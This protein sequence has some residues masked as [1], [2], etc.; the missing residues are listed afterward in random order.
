MWIKSKNTNFSVFLDHYQQYKYPFTV[1]IIHLLQM[2]LGIATVLYLIK[3]M[4][5]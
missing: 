2:F 4:I 3:I 5:L 1:L